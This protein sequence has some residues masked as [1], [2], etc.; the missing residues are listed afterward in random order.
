MTLILNFTL[1]FI[2]GNRSLAST[3]KEETDD[4][5]KAEDRGGGGGERRRKRKKVTRVEEEEELEPE[6]YEEAVVSD[7]EAEGES[8]AGDV[9]DE[10]GRDR[11]VESNSRGPD[12]VTPSGDD[13][14][15]PH[16]QLCLSGASSP[17]VCTS[18]DISNDEREILPG[19]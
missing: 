15:N 10:G 13:R 18:D 16:P 8:C 2:L 9:G 12:F 17:D 11:P 19:R 1:I 7:D 3:I 4:N 5:V 6:I 14:E